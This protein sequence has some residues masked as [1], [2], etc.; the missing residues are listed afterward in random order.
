MYDRDFYVN[1]TEYGRTMEYLQK[2]LES[3]FINPSAR[4]QNGTPTTQSVATVDLTGAS[5]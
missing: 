1:D 2:S 4:N 5:E 3:P